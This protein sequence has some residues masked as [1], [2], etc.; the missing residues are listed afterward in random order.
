MP[1]FLVAALYKFVALPDFENLKATDPEVAHDFPA[2]EWRRIRK[3]TGYRWIMV[4]GEVTF[5]EGDC[6]GSTPG[7]LLRHGSA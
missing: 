6:T 5:E 7:K 2:N 4:N 1:D 3:A